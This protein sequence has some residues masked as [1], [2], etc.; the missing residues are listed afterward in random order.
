MSATAIGDQ[1]DLP[2]INGDRARLLMPNKTHVDD[3]RWNWAQNFSLPD[4]YSDNSAFS[5]SSHLQ[6]LIPVGGLLPLR[7]LYRRNGEALREN[8]TWHRILRLKRILQHGMTLWITETKPERPFLWLMMKIPF[9]ETFREWF[10][11]ADLNA[12]VFFAPDAETALMHANE[13]NFDLAILD[14]NLGAGNNGLQLLEDLYYFNPDVVAIMITGFA[15][16]ATPLDAMRMG[17][18]DYFDKTQELTSEA[19]LQAVQKQLDYIRPAK[20]EKLVQRSL[21]A[22]RESVEQVLPLVQSAATLNDP[23]PLP[24]AIT[25]LFRLLMR[26]THA[27]DG[28]IIFRSVDESQQPQSYQAYN[29]QGEKI[30]GE[31][32]PFSQSLAGAIL[33]MGRAQRMTSLSESG[34]QLHSFEQGRSSLLGAPLVRDADAQVIVELF[35]KQDNTEGFTEQDRELV[36]SICELSGHLFHHSV[37]EQKVQRVLF[38]AIER[39]LRASD[40]FRDSLE[41]GGAEPTQKHPT[42]QVAGSAS[43][44]PALA[45]SGCDPR[46]KHGPARRGDSGDC[47]ATRRG[48][49]E[50]LSGA[51]RKSACSSR[52]G[53]RNG[54]GDGVSDSGEDV[55]SEFLNLLSPEKLLQHP[56]ATGEGVR[57]CVIDSGMEQ[58]ILQ[59]RAQARGTPCNPI[60]GAIFG[61]AP[62]EPLPYEGH[63]ST[64]HGT[65]VADIIL[66][67]APQVQL[68]SADVLGTRGSCEVDVV[69][70]AMQHAMDEWNCSVINVSLGVAEQRLQQGAEAESAPACGRRGVLP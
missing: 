60:Q 24:E 9:R 66:T 7:L 22:F 38:D 46:S 49:R 63:Q 58:S 56:Q 30:S 23:T 62:G 48:G 8:R 5:F 54:R 51:D 25:A 53:Q 2:T 14:W 39:A 36:E 6:I 68:Y 3:P 26:M 31:L 43:G 65:T 13:R 32:V 67:L 4:R 16:Q 55:L 34:L 40:Q 37:A 59:E 35:D 70:R 52:S 41:S 12:D 10:E 57:V 44:E 21:L 29:V 18:R 64:P 61:T 1:T 15:H 42:S 28:V 45:R 19:F 27:S 20:R 69:M 11:S 33:S 17:V 50:A 47:P